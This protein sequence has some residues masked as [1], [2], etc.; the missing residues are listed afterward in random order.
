MSARLHEILD[1]KLVVLE[2]R[3]QTAAEAILEIV[4]NLRENGLVDDF[5]KLADAVMERE[6]RTSTN[7]GEGVAF[8]HARTDLVD[9]LVLG[10]GRSKQGIPFGYSSELVHLIFL[11]GVPQ[12]TVTDYL[13]CVG[14]LARVVKDKTRRDALMAATTGEEF[15]EVLRE[16]SLEV[17]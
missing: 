11:V 5:Y 9:R 1:P 2:L 16:G 10:I 15:V 6:G 17:N 4:Q 8:P 3:E 12:R 13:V 7:T 14:E